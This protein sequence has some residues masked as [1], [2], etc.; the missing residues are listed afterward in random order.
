MDQRLQARG[1]EIKVRAQEW[2]TTTSQSSERTTGKVQMEGGR[3]VISLFLLRPRL[4]RNA[5][6]LDESHFVTASSVYKAEGIPACLG[7]RA[8]PRPPPF[9]LPSFAAGGTSCQD[10][11]YNVVLREAEAAFQ[12]RPEKKARPRT[13]QGGRAGV[14]SQ[15]CHWYLSLDYPS[16]EYRRATTI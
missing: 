12:E 1:K 16:I 6:R 11:V 14:E 15:Q 7:G 13:P 10:Q 5:E 3:H 4:L 8:R 2:G 9:L